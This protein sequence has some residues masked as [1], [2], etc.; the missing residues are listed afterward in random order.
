MIYGLETVHSILNG[1]MVLTHLI[2]LVSLEVEALLMLSD[3]VGSETPES[4]ILLL[5]GVDVLVD[6]VWYSCCLYF[7]FH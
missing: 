5:F 6:L 7:R 4:E 1:L 3:F 2:E